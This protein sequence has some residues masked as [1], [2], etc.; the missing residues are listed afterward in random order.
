MGGLDLS[1]RRQPPDLLRLESDDVPGVGADFEVPVSSALL[2]TQRPA[3]CLG[4]SDGNDPKAS[5]EVLGLHL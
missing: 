4:V 3:W 2:R 5:L 1:H